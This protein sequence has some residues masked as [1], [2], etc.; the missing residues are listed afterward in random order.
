MHATL[1]PPS[2][3]MEHRIEV[4]ANAPKDFNEPQL[5]NLERRPF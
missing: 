2:R 1:E 3:K 4:I 5:R